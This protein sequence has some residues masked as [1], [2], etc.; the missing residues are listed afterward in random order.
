[1]V[2]DCLVDLLGMLFLMLLNLNGV[3]H[4]QK[5]SYNLQLNGLPTLKDFTMDEDANLKVLLL[6]ILPTITGQVLPAHRKLHTLCC[7]EIRENVSIYF[8]PMFELNF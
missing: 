6:K 5:S 2:G 1:M 3:F 4:L 7:L 8:M